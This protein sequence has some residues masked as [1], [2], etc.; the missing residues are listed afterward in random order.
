VSDGAPD[1]A[2]QLDRFAE[3]GNCSDDRARV[4][5]PQLGRTRETVAYL[6][7]ETQVRRD[8]LF[9]TIIQLVD[10]IPS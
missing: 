2:R 8:D 6:A 7:R 3:A 5:P 9:R 10:S 1:P 4:N